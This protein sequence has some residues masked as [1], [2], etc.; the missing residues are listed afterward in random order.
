MHDL[1]GVEVLDPAQQLVEEH[2]DVVGREV[3]GGDD[4]F[5][6]VALHQLGNEV[7]FLKKV[8]VGGLK[9]IKILVNKIK[10]LK[11]TSIPSKQSLV[12]SINVRKESFY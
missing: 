7:D 6:E 3:L 10:K 11:I 5:V 8:D 4:D 12:C 1:G 2:L 9:I